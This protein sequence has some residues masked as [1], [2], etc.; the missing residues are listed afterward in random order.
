MERIMPKAV[1]TKECP[2]C[3][4]KVP[5]DAKRCAFCISDLT[6]SPTVARVGGPALAGSTTSTAAAEKAA[7]ET[8]AAEVE[9]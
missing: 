2:F 9:A 4:S 8:E 7:A 3:L 6:T 5:V 1:T